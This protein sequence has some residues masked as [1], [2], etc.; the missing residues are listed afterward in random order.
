MAN[1]GAANGESAKE[2]KLESAGATLHAVAVTP[3]GERV[4]AGAP[5]G[6]LY[7][8]DKDGKISAKIAVN[9]SAATPSPTPSFIRD[10]LPVL[11]KAGCNAGS[12]HAKPDGQN[13]FKLTAVFSFDPEIGLP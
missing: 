6:R 11:S 3:D 9:E 4:F 1:T 10:V 7:A 8:W 2:R 13:G 12:C 5:D